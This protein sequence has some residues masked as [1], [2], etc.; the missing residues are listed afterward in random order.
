MGQR[1]ASF[2]RCKSAARAR[3]MS[4]V[5]DSSSPL[6]GAIEAHVT[7]G[8]V[9]GIGGQNISRCA[10]ALALEVIRQGPRDLTLVG[11]NLSLHADLLVGAGLV[12]RLECGTGN[13]ERYGVTHRIAAGIQERTVETE[14][15]DHATMIARFIAAGTGAP[16]G[17]ISHLEGSDLLQ[18]TAPNGSAKYATV[19]NPWPP[20]GD[21]RVVPA[22]APDVALIHGLAADAEGN[23]RI[24]G[25]TSHDPELIRAAR[26]VVASVERVH[27]DQLFTTETTGTVIPGVYFDEIIEIPGGAW[28]TSTPGAYVHD[29]AALRGYQAA[30]KAG[31]AAYETQL[32]QLLAR[33]TAT[34]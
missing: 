24:V 18:E 33:P 27:R 2:H 22:L 9:V 30:A 13:L 12:R 16:F 5:R 14:D 34:P 20:H 23:V 1:I 25:P 10:V 11:C 21:I 3:V 6:Q 19:R 7:G 15:Y 17:I 8:S 26:K 29:D 28:P 4:G 31:G 32:D